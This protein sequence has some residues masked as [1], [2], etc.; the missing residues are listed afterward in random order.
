MQHGIGLC[1]FAVE[2]QLSAVISSAFTAAKTIKMAIIVAKIT[3][4]FISIVFFF[5]KRAAKTKLVKLNELPVKCCLAFIG[6]I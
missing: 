3:K 5:V 6:K 4:I 2:Q 1:A